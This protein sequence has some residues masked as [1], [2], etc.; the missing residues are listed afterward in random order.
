MY[1][2]QLIV[3]ARALDIEELPHVV[4]YELPNVPEDYVH[5]I[6]RTG[7]AAATGEALVA[8]VLMNTKLLRDIEKTAEKEIRALRF[9]AMSRTRQSKPN[10]SRTVASNVAA[11][12]VGKVV[13]AV[14]SNHAVGKVAQ[15]L[16]ARN[17]QKNRLA[18]S[19]M[20]N[21][22]ANVAAVRVNLPLRSNLCR[23]AMHQADEQTQNCLM[24]YA[25]QAYVNSAIY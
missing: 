13:V 16:Q 23:A 15:N 18:A 7:R 12:V 14:N 25:Y 11:A 5:R 21:R 3:A 20:P 1:W 24:R 4:N 17:L 8:G 6:G 10:R 22:Q 2:W 19:A 9:R